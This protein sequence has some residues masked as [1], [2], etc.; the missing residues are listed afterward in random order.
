[1]RTSSMSWR[2][3]KYWLDAAAWMSRATFV[4]ADIPTILV[5]RHIGTHA[6]ASALCAAFTSVK[7]KRREGMV[8]APE[9][10]SR[11]VTWI[12]DADASIA[13]LECTV[14]SGY[15]DIDRSLTSLCTD[16]APYVV[17]EKKLDALDDSPLLPPLS[18]LIR[19][20]APSSAGAGLH[21]FATWE[22]STVMP[23]ARNHGC[24]LMHIL[25]LHM[26]GNAGWCVNH[27][28]AMSCLH[29]PWSRL[30]NQRQRQAEHGA[31]AVCAHALL[32]L[33]GAL[34]VCVKQLDL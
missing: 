23:N 14:T 32:P 26:I 8:S 29:H 19:S 24:A 27:T 9:S 28:R 11:R 7:V 22:A 15:G 3:L 34:A 12:L 21:K 13:H 1:M 6:C 25:N 30:P 18:W 16:A 31:A 4:L 33:L 10:L 2:L 20:G 5:E 17:T